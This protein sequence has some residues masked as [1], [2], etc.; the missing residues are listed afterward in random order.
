MDKMVDYLSMI[1]ANDLKDPNFDPTSNNYEA[2][3]R[4]CWKNQP[5]FVKMYLDRLN[6]DGQDDFG[7]KIKIDDNRF[8][9]ILQFKLKC[10]KFA[11]CFK[12]PNNNNVHVLGCNNVAGNIEVLYPKFILPG[13][14]T[15]IAEKYKQ[16]EYRI[17]GEKWKEARSALFL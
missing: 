12:A 2:I 3:R 10:G 15:E 11:I 16:W 13:V 17:G 6:V 7:I 4:M 8:E 14:E 5:R 9:E 1:V